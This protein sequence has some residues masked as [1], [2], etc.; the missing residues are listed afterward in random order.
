MAARRSGTK[1]KYMANEKGEKRNVTDPK[2][3][4]LRKQLR[5]AEKDLAKAEAKRDKAQA[6]VEALTIIVDEIRAQL[7]EAERLNERM[8]RRALEMEGTCTGEHGIGQGK[9]R[10]LEP[11]HGP[12][13][14]AAMQAVKRALDPKGIMNPGKVLPGG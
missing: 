12:S 13:G 9:I 6:R 4:R 1:G 2:P 8:V 5:K 7:A 14:V 3:K 11:E 10:F